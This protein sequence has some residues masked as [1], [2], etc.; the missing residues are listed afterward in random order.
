MI[1][2]TA[3]GRY[4]AAV[5]A[6][7]YF[8]TAWIHSTGFDSITALAAD[9]PEELAALVPALWLA[10]SLDLVVLGLVIVAAALRPGGSARVVTAVAALCPFGA[11]ALQLRY[12]GFIPPTAILLT[13]GTLAAVAAGVMPGRVVRHGAS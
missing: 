8:A 9:G 6:L 1:S 2:R 3:V 10:F 4:I 12:I 13:I 7:G 5:A 11:A